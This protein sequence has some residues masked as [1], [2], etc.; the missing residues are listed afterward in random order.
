MQCVKCFSEYIF[1]FVKMVKLTEAEKDFIIKDAKAIG[2]DEKQLCF[3]D[4]QATGYKEGFVWILKT[5]NES[6]AEIY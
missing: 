6:N 4:Y 2:I 5:K 3:R 1:G